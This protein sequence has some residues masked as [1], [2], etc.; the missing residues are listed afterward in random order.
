M[1]E[2]KNRFKLD[3]AGEGDSV[4]SARKESGAA[5][6]LGSNRETPANFLKGIRSNSSRKVMCPFIKS[7]TFSFFFPLPLNLKHQT[8]I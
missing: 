3:L 7:E 1:S 4:L 6:A 8:L 5:K 2:F